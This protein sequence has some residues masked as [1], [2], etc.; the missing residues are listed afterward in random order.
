MKST[1]STILLAIIGILLSGC[2]K[3][4]IVNEDTS[5]DISSL[6]GSEYN[7]AI[8]DN[9]EDLVLLGRIKFN[10]IEGDLITGKWRLETWGEQKHFTVLP[11]NTGDDIP[12]NE[13]LD[14]FTG[15]V[16]SVRK[17]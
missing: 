4:N 14:D 8:L 16:S 6:P 13:Y 10:S 3:D 5:I 2:G 15:M 1:K 7:V 17:K 9:D 12:G 11:V